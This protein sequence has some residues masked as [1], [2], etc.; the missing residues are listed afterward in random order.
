M[1]LI[2]TTLVDRRHSANTILVFN[3]ITVVDFLGLLIVLSLPQA[4]VCRLLPKATAW[5]ASDSRPVRHV[6]LRNMCRL[7]LFACCGLVVSS[8]VARA[9]TGGVNAVAEKY[10]HLVLALGQ[11]DPDYVD[12]GKVGVASKGRVAQ[13]A[14]SEKSR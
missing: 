11:H 2:V 1:I 9:A 13:I 10:A 14:C 3:S 12:G 7:L 5:Q 8:G 6:F 4:T